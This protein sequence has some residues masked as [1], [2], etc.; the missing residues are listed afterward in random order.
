MSAMLENT[1]A[2]T[3]TNMYDLYKGLEL[4]AVVALYWGKLTLQKDMLQIVNGH[5]CSITKYCRRCI[6][7]CRIQEDNSNSLCRLTCITD[8]H[9]WL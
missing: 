9:S 8:L 7:R 1:Q 3:V 2:L 5:E 4:L 6:M